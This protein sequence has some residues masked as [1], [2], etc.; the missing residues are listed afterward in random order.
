MLMNSGKQWWENQREG[1]GENETISIMTEASWQDHTTSASSVAGG[2]LKSECNW[3]KYP[4][5]D[6]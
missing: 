6:L 1:P 4:P 5:R 2:S 3:S